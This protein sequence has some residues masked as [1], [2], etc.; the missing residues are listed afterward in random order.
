MAGICGTDLQ[1]LDGY[2]GFRGIPGH[3]F[4]GV[5]ESA[6]EPDRA[7]IGKRVVAEIN[8]GCGQCDWCRRGVKEHCVSRTVVGI[9][10]RGG[11]FAELVSVPAG[12]LHEIPDSI[13]D[14]T[15]VFVEPTAAA[16][17]VLE[18]IAIDRQARVAVLGDGR[19]GLLIAQVIATT[20]A[21]VTVFGRHDEKLAI[22]TALGLTCRRV[23]APIADERLFDIVID[24]TGRPEGLMRAVEL[25][26]PR[27]I[28]VMKSTF[29]GE[30]PVAS[31]PIVVNEVTLVG[32]RCGPFARALELLAA[33]AVRVQPLRDARD[34]PARLRVG[35][36][37]R[38]PWLE[39]DVQNQR[40]EGIVTVI[41]AAVSAA[42]HG[43]HRPPLLEGLLAY[44]GRALMV[45]CLDD[46][47]LRGARLRPSQVEADA[48]VGFRARS[49][50]WFD[51]RIGCL[52]RMPCASSWHRRGPTPPRPRANLE[53]GL[54]A[55]TRRDGGDSGV[56]FRQLHAAVLDARPIAGAHR[57]QRDVIGDLLRADAFRPLVDSERRRRIS[58]RRVVGPDRADSQQERRDRA[59]RRAHHQSD[60]D[61]PRDVPLAVA[62]QGLVGVQ[63]RR[64][65]R[66]AVGDS[67]PFRVTEKCTQAFDSAREPDGRARR[68]DDDKPERHVSG[69]RRAGPG[70][71]FVP[72]GCWS[73]F[74]S[75]YTGGSVARARRA[76]ERLASGAHFSEDR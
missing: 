22:G 29:H 39:G 15:A 37:R 6:P 54:R 3:E 8:I 68:S 23:D 1:L 5:V 50:S 36:R 10:G 55:D 19:L 63:F 32:S 35:V 75:E 59:G 40:Q 73:S 46:A 69:L 2:A 21:D 70:A 20:G 11:A 31:A 14:Q 41:V 42:V 45:F 16:C 49:R 62:A 52:A 18:Q 56:E 57:H 9:R 17:R 24:A 30:A 61:R 58:R 72:L 4:V 44:P 43:R 64:G 67:V 12:N 65:A 76:A 74:R 71:R 13:D 27:G 47:R 66:G 26:Q 51:T 28:V 25:A 34:E 7:W 48:Q 38:A 53:H 33:G 60:R